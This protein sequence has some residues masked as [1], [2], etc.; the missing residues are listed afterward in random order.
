MTL[1]AVAD[2][3]VV[4]GVGVR[5]RNPVARRGTA[6]VAVGRPVQLVGITAAIFVPGPAS[7][8][9][10]PEMTFSRVAFCVGLR[11]DSSVCRSSR[12]HRSDPMDVPSGRECFLPRTRASPA[13]SA[14][15]PDNGDFAFT[16]PPQSAERLAAL[17]TA[18]HRRFPTALDRVERRC[19]RPAVGPASA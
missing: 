4:F 11:A 8:R 9:T 18:P 5:V 16:R 15:R 7:P 14:G 13:P 2:A 12:M 19:R 10:A 3:L 6:G 1:A 17:G